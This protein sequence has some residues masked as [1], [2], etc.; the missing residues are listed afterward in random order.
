MRDYNI[1]K[2]LTPLIT[3]EFQA[4]FQGKRVL[5]TGGSGLLGSNFAQL[6][7][8]FSDDF[9]GNL[10]L[11]LVSKTG[12]FPFVPGKSV[13]T[14]QIDLTTSSIPKDIGKFDVVI[15]CAGYGQPTK[16]QKFPLK[17]IHLNTTTTMELSNLVQASGYFLFISTSEVYSGLDNPPFSEG[18]IGTTNTSHPR[19]SYIESK[20]TGE[21]IVSAMRT[22]FPGINSSA[23]RLALAY[24]PGTKEGDSRVLYE[25]IMQGLRNGE[26]FLRDSGKAIRTYCYVSDAVEQCL[27]ILM[28]GVKEVYNVGGKSRISI[29][30]LARAIG[31][32]LNVPVKIPEDSE[33]FLSDAPKDVWLDL[34]L[35]ELL[36]GKT[37]YVP[38]SEGLSRTI[39]W[40]KSKSD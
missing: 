5:I 27:Y 31:D 20:R 6:F 12:L 10:D 16:F 39:S 26:I 25:L 36:S 23:A 2:N 38:I 13:S 40:I 3:R 32:V 1:T 34:S 9:N 17:T 21:A 33:N 24:G 14:I 37:D 19:S 30:S 22:E 11:F 4:F 35:I 15:H 7:Q 28:R 29:A 8:T 18:Q